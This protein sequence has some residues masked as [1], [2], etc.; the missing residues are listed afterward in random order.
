MGITVG[1]GPSVAFLKII[2]ISV[3][4]GIGQSKHT[5]RQCVTDNHCKQ[6]MCDG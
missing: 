5:I 3:G 6:K 4:V 1:L 2:G